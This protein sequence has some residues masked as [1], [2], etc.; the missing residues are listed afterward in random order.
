MC[1]LS[2]GP[3]RLLKIAVSVKASFLIE[4]VLSLLA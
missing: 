2:T 1:S 4:M 3:A